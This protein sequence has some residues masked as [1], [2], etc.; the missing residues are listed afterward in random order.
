MEKAR[1]RVWEALHHATDN[2]AIDTDSI[3]R[4]KTAPWP[5]DKFSAIRLHEHLSATMM[6]RLH[7]GTDEK[8][9]RVGGRSLTKETHLQSQGIPCGFCD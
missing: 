3:T 8:E 1:T 2:C 9:E 5:T 7:T 4:H 6:L